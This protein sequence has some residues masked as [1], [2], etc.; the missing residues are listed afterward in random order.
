[1]KTIFFLIYSILIIYNSAI[2]QQNTD[3]IKTVL[4]IVDIQNFYF[5][6]DGPGL[7]NAIPASEKAKEILQIFR[8]KKQLV[9]HVRHKSNKGFEIHKNVEPIANEKIITKEEVNSFYKTDL[10]EYLKSNK[11]NRLIITGMQTHMCLEAAVRAAHDYGF[12]C[13]VVQDACA[14]KDLKF[15]DKTVKAED[16]HASTLSTLVV[17]GYAKVIDLD[18]FKASQEKFLFKKLD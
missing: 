18:V 12:E 2:S 6:G 17:G 13:V 1:M 16:V 7:V 10:L 14:T 3:T 15:G 11:I 8:D 9:I 5:P 4:L